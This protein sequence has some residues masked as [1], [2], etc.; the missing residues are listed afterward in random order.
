M[1]AASAMFA[2][3]TGLTKVASSDGAPMLWF[4]TIAM[5]GSGGAL[6]WICRITENGKI[7]TQTKVLIYSAI[8]GGLMVA[9]IAIN[10]VSVAHVGASFVSLAFVLPTLLTYCFAVAL[11]MDKLAALK[12]LAVGCGVSGGTLLAASKLATASDVGIGWVFLAACNP[13][14]MAIN[15]IYRTRHWPDNLSPFPASALM[16]LIGGLMFVPVAMM[17]DGPISNLVHSDVAIIL[18][19]VTILFAIQYPA[20][21]CVQYLSGPVFL[22]L[23]GPFIGVFGAAGGYLFLAEAMPPGLVLAAVL[24]I[25]GVLVFQFAIHRE[26]YGTFS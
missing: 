5:I 26:R 25:A 20:F 11:R 24:M 4:A 21:L 17:F 6:T 1:L 14:L 7:M 18:L 22:S 19:A 12:I 13:V 8:S 2:F 9:Y 15:N 16:L 23:S 10:F 3:V